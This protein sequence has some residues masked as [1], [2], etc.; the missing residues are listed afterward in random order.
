MDEDTRRLILESL[1]HAGQADFV[2]ARVRAAI[3]ADQRIGGRLALW[4]RRLMGEA[5]SQAQRVAAERDSL[6]ALLAGGIDR[7]GLDLAALTRMF[8]RL[9][10]NHTARMAELELDA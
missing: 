6:A 2:V 4:G 10:E 3:A 5:L 8:S 1:Q 9:T 7:P